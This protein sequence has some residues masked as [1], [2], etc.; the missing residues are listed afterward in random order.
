VFECDVTVDTPH[1]AQASDCLWK[2][3]A[4]VHSWMIPTN[5]GGLFPF[6]YTM[7][8]L[9]YTVVVDPDVDYSLAN[10]K[11]EVAAYLADPDGWIA[12][13]Y[14]FMYSD[15]NPKVVIHLSSPETLGKN[16]CMDPGLSCAEMNGKHLH[17]NFMR[18]TSGAAPSKLELKDYRQYMVSHEMGHILGFDHV[19]CPGTGKPAPIMMQQT[20]GIGKCSANTKVTL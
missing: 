15:K 14:E 17:L 18:W 11:R 16:G 10:L 13:G 1:L 8:T 9:S 20:L 2:G 5:L 4:T 6:L 12:H 19:K 3:T 7:K